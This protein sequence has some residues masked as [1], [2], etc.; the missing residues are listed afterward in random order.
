VRVLREIFGA[1]VHDAVADAG[2]AVHEAIGR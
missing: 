2:L 1:A